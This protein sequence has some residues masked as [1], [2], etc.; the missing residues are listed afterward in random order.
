MSKQQTMKTLI[1]LLWSSLIRVYTVCSGKSVPIIM[2]YVVICAAMPIVSSL[3]I[4]KMQLH[5]GG[6]KLNFVLLH[7]QNNGNLTLTC[8]LTPL[9]LLHSECPKLHR[10]LAVLSAIGLK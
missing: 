8:D 5:L 6:I 10:V 7:I 9:I 2:V 3:L 4:I 1:R